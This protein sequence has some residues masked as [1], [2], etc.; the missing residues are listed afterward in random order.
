MISSRLNSGSSS[1]KTKK[2]TTSSRDDDP[3]GP[4]AADRELH[5]PSSGP[6]GE[7]GSSGP[8]A[9]ALGNRSASPFAASLA[10]RGIREQAERGRARAGHHRVLGAGLGQRL[11]SVGD[12]GP[13]RDRRRLQVV[14]QVLGVLE[15]R[16][17]LDDG[18]AQLA[19]DRLQLGL[20]AVPAEAVGLG[21]DVGGGQAH[22]LR[23]QHD[24]VVGRRRDRLDHLAGARHHAGPGLQLRGH[25]RAD[26]GRDG[27]QA[28]E[29]AARE[30]QHGGGVGAAAPEP[31]RDRD[32]LRDLHAQRRLRPAG[33]RASPPAPSRPGSARRPRRRSPRRA[34]ALASTVSLSASSSGSKIEAISCSPSSRVGPT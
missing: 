25:V 3:E 6:T 21:V 34:V 7:P 18:V 29:L 15:R 4:L 16:G 26:G 27:A 23:D 5:P 17:A 8:V 24:A 31:G 30:A 32:P 14:D 11:Q 19:A 12:L 22:R 20:A 13:Q 9:M 10:A 28:V 33:S 1:R 2:A